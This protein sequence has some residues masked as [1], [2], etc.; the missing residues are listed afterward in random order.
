MSPVVSINSAN[1]SNQRSSGLSADQERGLPRNWANGLVMRV[2]QALWPTKPDIVLSDK[3]KRS[4]RLCRYWLENKYSLGADDLVLLLR[5][6]EGLHVLEGI[7][8]DA[9]PIWWRDFKRGVKRAELRRQQKAI[10]KALD[11]DEQGELQV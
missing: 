5:T 9:R 4:D 10:Q 8:G 2:A 3:T 1:R 6:D 7:M 11:E